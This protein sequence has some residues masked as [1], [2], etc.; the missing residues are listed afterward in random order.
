[1]QLTWHRYKY[2]PYEKDLAL[3]EIKSLIDPYA[4]ETNSHGIHATQPSRPELASRLVY[5]AGYTPENAATPIETQQSVLERINGNGANRQST[6][7]SAHGLH[8][9]KGKFNPQVAKAIL[10]IFAAQ[11]G[12]AA[13]DPFCGSGTSLVE[14]AHLGVDAVGTDINPLAVFIANAKLQS[15]NISGERLLQDSALCLAKAKSSRQVPFLD[16]ERGEYL[17]SWFPADYLTDIEQL[18]L[19]VESLGGVSSKV[20]LAIASNLLRDY[21]LQEPH[22][23]RIR[24]RKS[25]FPDV[26]FFQAYEEAV[27]AFCARLSAAQQTLGFVEARQRAIHVDCKRAQDHPDLR[28]GTFDLALTSPPYATALPYIDTQRL[29]L[30]WLGLLAPSEILTLE[31]ELIGSREIRGQGKKA[32]L[33]ALEM[34]E[35][36]LPETEADLCVRLQHALSEGD[37]FRR[38]V[39]PRLLYRYFSG[40]SDAFASVRRLVKVNAPFGL[41]VGGNHTVL[42]GTRFDINTPEHLANLAAARGWQ[43]IETI[44]LQTY[45]RYGLHVNN[46]T[47]TEALVILRAIAD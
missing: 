45:Q 24:R 17:R 31:A 32:L 33:T 40:M 41:I 46:A 36:R 19:A 34:N 42:G 26:P 47:T 27:R 43:H 15:L 1:M 38:Q 28:P 9:Y 22:D 4:I 30:V 37:G 23:L 3:R 7:Y 18:R 8:E 6:R 20:L 14:S 11:P 2:Y 29:S 10:N 35:A 16:D 12:Q 25:P 44:P 39:V 21:S 13:I 5:F